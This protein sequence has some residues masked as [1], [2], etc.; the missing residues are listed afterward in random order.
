MTPDPYGY[1][2]IEPDP[3]HDEVAQ[4]RCRECG[5]LAP[6]D[7]DHCPRCGW[8][9]GPDHEPDDHDERAAERALER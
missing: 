2:G 5:A 9:P 8:S 3:D 6:R 4:L 7:F 1:E